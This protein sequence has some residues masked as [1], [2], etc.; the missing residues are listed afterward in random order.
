M[1]VFFS[2]RYQPA[3]CLINKLAKQHS[4]CCGLSS[5]CIDSRGT[6]VSAQRSTAVSGLLTF[7]LSPS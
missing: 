2:Q 4:L 3:L 7:M 5:Q 6:E 1:V